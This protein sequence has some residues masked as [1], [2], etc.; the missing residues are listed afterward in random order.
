[1]FPQNAVPRLLHSNKFQLYLIS[2]AK[3]NWSSLWLLIIFKYK[4]DYLKIIFMPVAALWRAIMKLRERNHLGKG[5][6]TKLLPGGFMFIH[7]PDCVLTVISVH[8]EFCFGLLDSGSCL[9][10]VSKIDLAFCSL[11]LL[12]SP[13]PFLSFF[14]FLCFEMNLKLTSQVKTHYDHKSCLSE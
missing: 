8:A 10:T 11:F 1:M 7:Y 12:S 3:L 9:K 14:P 2:L 6:P 4:K 5:Y 13:H